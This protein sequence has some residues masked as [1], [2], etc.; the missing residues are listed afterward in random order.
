MYKN[1]HGSEGNKTVG[2]ALASTHPAS[3]PRVVVLLCKNAISSWAPFVPS[4]LGW[5]NDHAG[6]LPTSHAK[7]VSWIE[8]R[9]GWIRIHKNSP[10]P[11]PP[12]LHPNS[13]SWRRIDRNRSNSVLPTYLDWHQTTELSCI[14]CR[15]KTILLFVFLFVSLWLLNCLDQLA[16]NLIYGPK[17]NGNCW[18]AICWVNKNFGVVQSYLFNQ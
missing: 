15:S 13:Y 3:T 7:K 12:P 11:S 14:F 16:D 10:P 17:R 5:I 2:L 6:T 18:S 9:E 4:P 1:R 8:G